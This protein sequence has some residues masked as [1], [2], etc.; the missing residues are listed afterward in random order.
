MTAPKI[1]IVQKPVSGQLNAR[2]QRIGRKLSDFKDVHK[3]ASILLDRWVQKN[4]KAEGQGLSSDKWPPF[5]RGG[6]WRKG[7]GLDTSAKLLQDTGALRISFQPFA[8][9]QD[10]GI[11]SVLDYAK[12]HEEG[13]GD[14][15]K[16]RML[17][18]P[19]EVEDTLTELFERHVER[20]RNA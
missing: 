4:F 18:E 6:R 8:D 2:L 5:A 9:S 10:A 7:F 16:R 3:E 15:P 13:T 1:T 14:I 19:R 12:Y 11:G 17:P 20:A